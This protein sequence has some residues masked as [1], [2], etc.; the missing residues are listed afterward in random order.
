MSRMYKFN[1][2]DGVYFMVARIANPR[3][4]GWT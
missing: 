1:N 4:H 2:P 3:N